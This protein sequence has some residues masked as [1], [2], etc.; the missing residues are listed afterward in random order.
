MEWAADDL[1]DMWLMQSFIEFLGSL[2]FTA[3]ASLSAAL[4]GQ[5]DR[6]I[7]LAYFMTRLNGSRKSI[8]FAAFA[9]EAF[10]NRLL[11]NHLI[12]KDAETALRIRPVV[13]KFSVGSRMALG[14]TLF[15]RDEALY[16]ELSKLFN[17]RNRLV[18]A[19]PRKISVGEFFG[20]S[21]RRGQSTGREPGALGGR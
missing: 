7:G 14:T 13:E 8:A 4:S 16:P 5:N 15:P 1:S 12:G 9:A 6:H 19:E 11:H 20:E 21:L 3:E 10:I 2:G 17:R 18:H